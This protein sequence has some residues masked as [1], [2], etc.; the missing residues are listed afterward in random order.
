ME[1]VSVAVLVDA[2]DGDIAAIYSPNNGRMNNN[3]EQ[4]NTRS[5]DNEFDMERLEF[6]RR[7]VEREK[8]ETERRERE[9]R[10]RERTEEERR[11]AEERRAFEERRRIEENRRREEER[12]RQLPPPAPS[13]PVVSDVTRQ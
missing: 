9:R 8:R 6:E 13:R 2:C 4:R 11:R 12:K 3:G 10:D 1:D 5:I 7:E